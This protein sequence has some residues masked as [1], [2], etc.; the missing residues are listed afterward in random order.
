MLNPCLN[1]KPN[2]IEDTLKERGKIYGGSFLEQS[3]IAQNLKTAIKNS[4]NWNR[5]R[6]DQRE[7]LEMIATKISRILYGDPNHVDSWHDIVGY[8]SLIERELKK[9]EGE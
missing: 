5:M 3:Q 6:V 8:A 1:W 2:M 4:P 9:T 7:A